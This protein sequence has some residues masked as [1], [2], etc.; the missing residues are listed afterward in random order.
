[1][2]KPSKVRADEILV[3]L[4]LASSAV[5]ARALIMAG[6]VMATGPDNKERKIEKAGE[7]LEQGSTIRLLGDRGAFVS[8]GGQKLAPALDAFALDVRGWVCADIGLST[9]GFTDCLLRR[10]ALRVHGVDVGYGQVDWALRSDPRLVLH[11]RTNARLLV[12][13]AFGERVKLATVDVSFIALR[14]VLEPIRAQLTDD[15]N[16]V[17]LVKPQFELKKE[18]VQHGVVTDPDAR[19]R[20]VDGVIEAARAI[21]LEARGQI[22]S[23]VPGPRGNVEVLVHLVRR[24]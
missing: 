17:A 18:E 20:A 24:G 14:L 13:D 21:A 5:Q 2:S 10:G 9:G 6:A 16:I 23:S 3:D 11:E 12:P 1:M 19:K 8:R 7:L 22:D 4:G 15:G